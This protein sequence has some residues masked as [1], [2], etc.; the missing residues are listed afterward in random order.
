VLTFDQ[1]AAELGA[2]LDREVAYRRVTPDEYADL[3]RPVL[4]PKAAAGVAAG[5]AAMPEEPSPLMAPDSTAAW[6][7]LGFSPTRARD[8]A[9]RVLAARVQQVAVAS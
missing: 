8:W 5:Y 1:L 2:G 4:G 9:A 6:A 3:L 7:E